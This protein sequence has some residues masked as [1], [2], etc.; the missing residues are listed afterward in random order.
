MAEA[1]HTDAET[2]NMV[3]R[4]LRLPEVERATGKKRSSIY[5]EISEGNFP[6]PIKLGKKAVGW[7][8]SEIV[9]WVQAKIGVRDRSKAAA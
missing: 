4:I 6:K 3:Q 8:E 9:D 2:S 1:A 5:K 7:V